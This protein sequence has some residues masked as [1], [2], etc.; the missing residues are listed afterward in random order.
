M[1]T[2]I[3]NRITDIKELIKA[4]KGLYG[5]IELL[6]ERLDELEKLVTI[7]EVGK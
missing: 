1:E 4:K 7:F 3:K 2:Y 6:N 5:E